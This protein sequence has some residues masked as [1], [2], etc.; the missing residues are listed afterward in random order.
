MSPPPKPDAKF[1]HLLEYLG[2]SR[3]FDFTGYK[4]PSLMRRVRQRMET[5][6]VEDFGDYVDY[7]EV[8]SENLSFCSIISS[9]MSRLFFVTR[10]PGNA[11]R[12]QSCRAL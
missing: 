12:N 8:H 9:S 4:R 7:L 6:D 2:Q 10:R 3:G 11:W 5:V 1:E